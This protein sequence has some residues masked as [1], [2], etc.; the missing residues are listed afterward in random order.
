MFV[1]WINRIAAAPLSSVLFALALAMIGAQL[2]AM[3]TLAQGQVH[4]ALLRDSQQLSANR[5]LASCV[6]S[7]RGVALNNCRLAT[8]LAMIP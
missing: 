3:A 8:T 4:K 5:A 2:Y 1:K 7:S 6:Q